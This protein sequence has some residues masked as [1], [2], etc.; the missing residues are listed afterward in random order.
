MVLSTWYSAD[1]IR[2]EDTKPAPVETQPSKEGT[3]LR[4][5]LA[6]T[7]FGILILSVAVAFISLAHL[8][9]QVI[10]LLP[11]TLI[12]EVDSAFR[13]VIF[14]QAVFSLATSFV[15]L[16]FIYFAIESLV[17]NPVRRLTKALDA[18]ALDGAHLTLQ[19]EQ[20]G[21]REIRS[22]WRSVQALVSRIDEVHRR[23][24]EMSRMKTDFISTAAHQF[25]TPL[26]GI[27]W[28]LEALEKEP[29]TPE[30]LALVKSAVGKSRDLVGVVG[31]LLDISSI[32]SG[33]YRYQ[34]APTDMALLGA[35]V[36]RD[37]AT[38]AAARQVSVFFVG[39]EEKIPSARADRERVKWVLNNLIENAIR[40]TPAG[41][42][43]RIS[44][45][46]GSGLIFTSVKDTGIGIPQNDRANIFER[47]YRAGNAIQKE[48]AGSGLGLYIART[49]A[50][51]HGGELSF[52]AN[53]DGPG[54]TF[55]LSLPVAS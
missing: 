47:F 1:S 29:L 30:Q 31:T 9:E 48:N 13:D 38:M 11:E 44:I 41:G 23:D 2:M 37:F 19:G 5:Q 36:A 32:E 6:L 33:K 28:A 51:D 3:G 14:G 26:T 24:V 4:T 39:G 40:Y 8:R 21:P 17:T 7:L 15:L 27:R 55:T 49:I 10:D 52:S 45:R 50:K 12:F 54:T 20:N 16:L 18:F 25:R 34:F 46:E 53:T 22:L 35:E 43:V 42:N